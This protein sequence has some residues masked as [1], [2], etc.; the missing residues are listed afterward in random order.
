MNYPSNKEMKEARDQF[1]K[2]LTDK[3]NEPLWQRFFT[4][5]P[6]VF[7]KSLPIKLSETD[8]IPLGRPGITEPDFFLP[9]DNWQHDT[10]RCDRNKEAN[11]KNL[12]K[13]QEGYDYF[14]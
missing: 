1:K 9:T 4:D 11:N 5:Y 2:L 8:I 7:S 12:H 3:A 13:R 14:I 10:A 6:F